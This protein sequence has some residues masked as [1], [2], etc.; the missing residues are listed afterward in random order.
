MINVTT[1]SND[2][3]TIGNKIPINSNTRFNKT[4]DTLLLAYPVFVYTT[5][6]SEVQAVQVRDYFILN[7][8]RCFRSSLTDEVLIKDLKYRFRVCDH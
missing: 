1:N 4:L 5:L 6:R 7:S 3:P 8:F 2:T